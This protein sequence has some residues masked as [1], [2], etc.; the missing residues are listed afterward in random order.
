MLVLSVPSPLQPNT[1]HPGPE[2]SLSQNLSRPREQCQAEL[3]RTVCARCPS[4]R[5]MEPVHWVEICKMSINLGKTVFELSSR[6]G[7]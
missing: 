4:R 2:Q 7:Y 3:G 1:P 6:G 5:E